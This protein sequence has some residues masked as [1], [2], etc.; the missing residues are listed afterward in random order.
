MIYRMTD[1]LYN[2]LRDEKMTH[3]AIIDYV[4]LN[5]CGNGETFKLG[6]NEERKTF[7]AHHEPIRKV[8][9][10]VT[11]PDPFKDKRKER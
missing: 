9:D 2:K 10:I 1:Y 8:T 11:Y 4:N 5:F 6:I 3:S 7:I